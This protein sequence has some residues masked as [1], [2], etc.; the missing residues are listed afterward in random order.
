M[1]ETAQNAQD[2]LQGSEMIAVLCAEECAELVEVREER[3]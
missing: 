2:Q 3:V 1:S